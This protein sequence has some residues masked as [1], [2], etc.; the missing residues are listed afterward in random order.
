ME[1]RI[2]TLINEL[3][4][5]GTYRHEWNGEDEFGRNVPAGVYIVWLSV[6]NKITTKRLLVVR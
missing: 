5:K 1:Y 4:S 2:K 3:A 6:D